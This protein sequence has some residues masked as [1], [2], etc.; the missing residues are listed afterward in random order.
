MTL[1][2]AIMMAMAV[3]TA[4]AFTAVLGMI[5]RVEAGESFRGL[6]WGGFH[7]GLGPWP[8][9]GIVAMIALVVNDEAS[10]QILSF[11]YP[12]GREAEARWLMPRAQSV[13]V[14]GG[15]FLLGAGAVLRR[16]LPHAAPSMRL[17]A[18]QAASPT[19]PPD[20]TPARR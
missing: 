7:R 15:V 4:V 9:L 19:A 8:V 3:A 16:A 14:G 20:H 17:R 1:A 5:C 13:F 10:V 18:P 12:P 11:V 2:G 6:A